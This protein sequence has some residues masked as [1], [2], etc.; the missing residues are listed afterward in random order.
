M[1]NKIFLFLVGLLSLTSC[2][3]S[4]LTTLT[5]DPSATIDCIPDEGMQRIIVSSRSELAAIIDQMGEPGTPQSRSVDALDLAYSNNQEEFVS[6][7]EADRQRVMS[8][9]TPEQLA[10]I[11]AEGLEYSATDSVIA[12][13]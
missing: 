4:A 7:L 5:E 10:E 6:L 11:D 13:A 9:L 12:D 2:T 3:E 8:S 1:K